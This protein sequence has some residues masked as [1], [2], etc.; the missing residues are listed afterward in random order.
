M[1]NKL[2]PALI[3]AACMLAGCRVENIGKDLSAGL[4]KNMESIAKNLMSGVNKGLSDSAFKQ[5]LYQLVDS[6]VGTAG[7]SANRSVKNIIDSLTSDQLIVFT[8]RMIE[9]ATGRQLRS[10]VTALTDE[11]QLTA[12]NLLGEDM[13]ARIRLLVASALDE[14]SGGKLQTTIALLRDEMTGPA[15]RDNIAALRDS[16]LNSKTN[17]AIKA[18]VD[19]AMVA[20]A[21]RLKNDVNPQL[22]QN[23]SFIQRNATS[24]LIVLGVIALVII[25]VIWRLKEK[26]AKMTTVIASQIHDIK[27]QQTYDALT[28]NIKEKAIAAGVEPSLRKMLEENGMLGKESREGWQA[29]K[30]AALENKN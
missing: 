18:L 14:V 23:L 2:F 29:K 22:Q 16:L 1:K 15:L 27:D 9:E 20:F 24:L 21:Y 6:L 13:R 28:H 30:A 3:G 4:N 12:K 11:I 8:R 19:T 25:I 17:T 7:S 26:Y 5:N 10:N